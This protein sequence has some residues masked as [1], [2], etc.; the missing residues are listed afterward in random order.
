RTLENINL[1]IYKGEGSFLNNM[2]SGNNLELSK[3]YLELSK[4]HK[5]AFIQDTYNQF[6]DK[7]VNEFGVYRKLGTE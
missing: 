2:V 5:M 1:D 4:M 3:I 7:R 6:L